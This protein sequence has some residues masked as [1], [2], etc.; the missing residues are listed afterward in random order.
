MNN[1][2]S[3][4]IVA[5][6]QGKRKP[7]IPET[8][9]N[10]CRIKQHLT[11]TRQTNG[12]VAVRTSCFRTSSRRIVLTASMQ[13]GCLRTA[14]SPQPYLLS[15]SGSFFLTL[16]QSATTMEEISKLTNDRRTEFPS[17]SA[18]QVM[19]PRRTGNLSSRFGN[20]LYH[21]PLSNGPC[22]CVSLPGINATRPEGVAVFKG[23]EPLKTPHPPVSRNLSP[24]FHSGRW[25]LVSDVIA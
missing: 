17:L 8:S 12:C 11:E 6:R 24:G 20:A 7:P 23:S 13:T 22:R 4:I 14:R 1:S 25:T 16:P 18:P 2:L 5:G 10:C 3:T 9:G 21:S 19:S 15:G